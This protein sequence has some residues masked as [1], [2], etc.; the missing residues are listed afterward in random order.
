MIRIELKSLR[1]S[2]LEDIF[3]KIAILNKL[4]LKLKENI[5]DN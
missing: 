3:I 5:F 4:N 2:N 1:I